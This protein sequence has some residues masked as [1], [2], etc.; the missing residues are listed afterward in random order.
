MMSHVEDAL[1]ISVERN[2]V[3]PFIFYTQ[4]PVGVVSGVTN[5]SD[6]FFFL[7]VFDIDLREMPINVDSY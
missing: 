1:T 7:T 2:R 4:R 3:T 5:A 6:Y